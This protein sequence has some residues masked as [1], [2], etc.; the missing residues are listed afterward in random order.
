MRNRVRSADRKTVQQAA[1]IP[2]RRVRG[3]VQICLIRR[4]GA[5][6]WGIPKGLVEPGD[7]RK[8]TALNEAWEEAGLSGQVVGKTIGTYKY[9]KLGRTLK[10]SV[11]LMEVVEQER[12]W[13]EA[14][15]RERRWTA[16]DD[17]VSLLERHPVSPLLPR[18][19]RRI[20]RQGAR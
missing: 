6:S 15:F 1:A 14:V 16:L 2:V 18:A 20:V 11:Y 19:L 17:A 12:T 5:R 9:V 13:E 4:K 8:E 7:T 10:V 3:Q